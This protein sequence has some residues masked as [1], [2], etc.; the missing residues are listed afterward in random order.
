MWSNLISYWTTA[1]WWTWWDIRPGN[2][3]PTDLSYGVKHLPLMSLQHSQWNQSGFILPL[4]WCDKSP[5]LGGW[6]WGWGLHLLTS[7]TN[8]ST[9]VSLTKW[10]KIS[11]RKT[12]K[13]TKYDSLT[14]LKM[15]PIY[16]NHPEND[17][18]KHNEHRKKQNCHH[19]TPCLG[20]TGKTNLL[21]THP[22]CEALGS[23]NTVK[24]GKNSTWESSPSNTIAW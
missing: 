21:R 9:T 19:P 12:N 13:W 20:N 23:P 1:L 18:I 14:C 24:Q 8:V 11:F 7:N 3:A 22:K 5:S 10:Q 15:W 6:G 16:W 4:P 17:N 2:L